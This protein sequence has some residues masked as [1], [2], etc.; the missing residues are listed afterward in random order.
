MGYFS[1]SLKYISVVVITIPFLVDI[2]LLQYRDQGA[3]TWGPR[4]GLRGPGAP[5]KLCGE[6]SCGDVMYMCLGKQP[7][8]SI[9]FSKGCVSR[10]ILRMDVLHDL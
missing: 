7:I 6:F 4:M 5:H 3:L 9:R 8:I 10:E 1:Q 2:T